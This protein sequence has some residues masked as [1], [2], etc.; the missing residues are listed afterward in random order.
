MA[1]VGYFLNH[2]VSD[3]S[4]LVYQYL[5][6]FVNVKEDLLDHVTDEEVHNREH[7]TAANIC[8]FQLP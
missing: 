6:A 8:T 4:I 1:T 2:V 3:T 5:L 7:D